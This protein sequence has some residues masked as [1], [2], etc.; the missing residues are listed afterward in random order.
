LIVIRLLDP[1]EEIH[2]D[3]RYLRDA[4]KTIKAKT[5]PTVEDFYTALQQAVREATTTLD[6]T[7]IRDNPPADFGPESTE[8]TRYVFDWIRRDVRHS[9]RRIIS[10]R[11]EA[12]LL[13]ARELYQEVAELPGYHVRVLDWSIPVPA[14]NMAVVDSSAVFLALTGETVER[15]KGLAIEDVTTAQYFEDYYSTLW[16]SSVDLAQYLGEIG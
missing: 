9:V 4:T 12:M 10:I 14:P 6:L 16:H 15:T 13:W 8:Y 11:N 5:F 7:H 1:V 2:T 3:V